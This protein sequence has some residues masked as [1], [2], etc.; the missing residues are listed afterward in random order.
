MIFHLATRRGMALVLV[1][2]C[3]ALGAIIYAELGPARDATP[4]APAAAA[5]GDPAPALPPQPSSF[6]LPPIE[7]YAEVA[8]RPLFSPTRQPPPPEAAQDALGKS[9]GFA[10]IGIIIVEDGRIAL[11]QHG[12]PPVLARL[13]E[14]QVVEGWTVQSILPDRVMLQHGATE[15]ELKLRDRP[16]Q[17]RQPPPAARG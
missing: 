4:A 16:A 15:H 3:L 8:Q 1:A 10:L 6:T 11:I 2:L 14:G 17:P 12:R 7:T 5:A 13:K 9:S